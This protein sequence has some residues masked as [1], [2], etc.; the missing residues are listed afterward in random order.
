MHCHFP[1]KIR[2]SQ[3][4]ILDNKVA[5][6]N[7]GTG[8]VM[9]SLLWDTYPIQFAGDSIRY[10]ELW[11]ELSNEMLPAADINW[12][13]AA[14][15]IQDIPEKLAVNTRTELPQ[16]LSQNEDSI[17]FQ[18]STV[19]PFNYFSEFNFPYNGWQAFADS[20]EVYVYS[21]DELPLQCRSQKDDKLYKRSSSG[22]YQYPIIQKAPK[23]NMAR[24]FADFSHGF[25]D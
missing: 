9:L 20:L 3:K 5:L 17:Y 4:L 12:Q 10:H 6:E 15:L 7:S 22:T 2:H 21:Q 16:I 13:I 25:V 18:A 19:N 8:K 11:T 1:L 23:G 24:Y 14:P